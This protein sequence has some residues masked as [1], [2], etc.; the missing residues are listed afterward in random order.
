MNLGIIFSIGDSF[1]NMAKSGQDEL[2]NKFYVP[3]FAKSF[4]KVYI[5]S[6]SKEKISN[7]PHNVEVVPNRFNL[8]RYFYA[9]AMPFLNARFFIKCDIF[10][11]YHT[12]GTPPAIISRIFLSKPYIFNYA[13]D[14]K[15][16]A[17]IEGKRTQELLIAVLEPVALFFASKIFIGNKTIQRKLNHLNKKITYLPNGVDINF[18]KP[19]KRNQNGQKPTILS[20]G[21]LEKQKNFRSL[22]K[23][24]KGINVKLVIV[25][26]G[27]LKFELKQIAL[28]YKVNLEIIEKVPN[29][30]MPQIYNRADIFVLPSLIEG[31]PK[32]LLEA[33]ASSLP[34]IGT[35]VEGI[36]EIIENGKD[37]ILVKA[38]SKQISYAV[39]SLL[40]NRK[41]RQNLGKL[42]RIKVKSKFNLVKLINLEIK[43]IVKTCYQ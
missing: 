4:S 17:I 11:V 38:D 7:L 8:H 23:A 21:R 35:Q 28:R 40:N 9:I 2:L 13:Y 12:L 32:A 15:K 41:L 37:G 43:E 31:S 42:A 16:F 30:T 5:F 26:A 18:F 10:R 27:S 3:Y 25:G 29:T 24:L 36:E 22:V 19:Q 33:M 20:V 1:E 14:Y 6:Y 34:I 39:N